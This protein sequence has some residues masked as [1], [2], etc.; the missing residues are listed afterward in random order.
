MTGFTLQL[1]HTDE[2][3]RRCYPVMAQLRTRYDEAAFVAQVRTQMTEDGYQLLAAI[4]DGAVRGV[5]GFVIATKL[6]W[7]KH[8]YIDDLITDESQRSRGA[9]KA[10]LDWLADYGREHGCVEL[11]LDSGVQRFD[12]HRFY[13]RE[14]MTIKSHHFDKPL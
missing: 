1:M 13:F 7:G 2:Q 11:H 14:G 6:A 9:G 8:V 3:L 12:A 10:L 4:E 5:A